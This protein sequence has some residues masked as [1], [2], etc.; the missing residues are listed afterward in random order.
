[1]YYGNSQPQTLSLSTT[2]VGAFTVNATDVVE[3][4]TF[5]GAE[6]Q[7]LPYVLTI[8]ATDVAGHTATEVVRLFVTNVDH[9]PTVSKFILEGPRELLVR[10]PEPMWAEN[11]RLFTAFSTTF[12]G[13]IT[14]T[15]ISATG[16]VKS[17]N[18]HEIANEFVV[19]FNYNVWNDQVGTNEWGDLSNIRMLDANNEP[20]TDLAGNV[21]VVPVSHTIIPPTLSVTPE[22]TVYVGANQT[23]T[24]AIAATSAA[25]IKQTVGYFAGQTKVINTPSGQMTFTSPNLNDETR[26]YTATFVT[27]DKSLDAN[28][29]SKTRVVYVNAE[30]PTVTINASS[31]IG[32]DATLTVTG[33]ATVGD[34]AGT[35]VIDK[36]VVKN[37]TNNVTVDATFN[38]ASTTAWIATFTGLQLETATNTIQVTVTDIYGNVNS[39]STTVYVDD[40]VPTIT[41]TFEASHTN[42]GNIT[43]GSSGT[44]YVATPA[45]FSWKVTTD[46]ETDATVSGTIAK[47]GTAF[48]AAT[49]TIYAT[50][51]S[52]FGQYV[53]TITATNPISKKAATFIATRTIVIDNNA[54]TVSVATPATVLAASSTAIATYTATDTNFKSAELVLTEGSTV[55][56][57]WTLSEKASSATVDLRPYL[58]NIKGAT[59]TVTITATDLALNSKSASATFYVDTVSPTISSVAATETG[60]ATVIRIY[61]S[62]RVATTTAFSPNNIVFTYQ[63]TTYVASDIEFT[64]NATFMDVKDFTTG[65]RAADLPAADWTVTVGN[66]V[67]DIAGNPVSGTGKYNNQ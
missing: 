66:N 57:T 26:T 14:S 36:I 38:S 37:T 8:N 11:F 9:T 48:A 46:S 32:A 23:V 59:V 3:L 24:Y 39:T 41:V 65:L 17:Y 49:S 29:A 61:F 67:T 63:T 45:T 6:F 54:P 18:G 33:T 12:G 4:P 47:D 15:D 25:G 42:N 34:A 62:E 20:I 21:F 43:N 64:P 31:I 16:T 53:I 10:L 50:T 7:N 1:L 58:D 22:A 40:S 2:G 27:T 56:N 55:L 5:V 30:K 13:T 44:I 35:N 28:Q 60:G 19:T 52:A 51:V